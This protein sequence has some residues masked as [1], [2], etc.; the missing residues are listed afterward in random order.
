MTARN[1]VVGFLGAYVAAWRPGRDPDHVTVFN[2]VGMWS[3]VIDTD[4]QVIAVLLDS[5]PADAFEQIPALFFGDC[6]CF[7]T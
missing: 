3:L 5:S 1:L 6:F 2:Q 7:G 4:L